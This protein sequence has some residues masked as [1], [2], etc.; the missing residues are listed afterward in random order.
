MLIKSFVHYNWLFCAPLFKTVI[1][2][3]LLEDRQ[4]LL[5]TL[6]QRR[7]SLMIILKS[8][9]LFQLVLQENT[10]LPYHIPLR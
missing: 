9:M 10:E 6:L 4:I 3:V 8:L 1:R 7:Q 2:L 5:L